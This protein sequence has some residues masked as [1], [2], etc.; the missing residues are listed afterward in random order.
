MRRSMMKPFGVERRSL[1]RAL[2]VGSFAASAWPRLAHAANDADVIVVGAGLS[3]L[4]A[5]LALEEAGK[6]VIVVEGRDRVGGRVLTL[7]VFGLPEVGGK[8]IGGTY[9]R[10]RALCERF[11][12]ELVERGERT[13]PAFA[14]QDM[15]WKGRHY[16]RE[17]WKA[18]A[19]NPFEGKFREALPWEVVNRFIA[20]KNPFT[21]VT[22]WV[23]PVKAAAH[24]VSVHQFLKAQNWSEAQIALAYSFSTGYGLSTHDVSM[25]MLFFIA[26]F[27]RAN[28]QADAVGSR[29][30]A[31]GNQRLP[32]AMAKGLRGDVVLNA[33]VA[34]LRTEK[35]YAEA[36]LEDGR[37]LR[38]KHLVC[39]L[40]LSAMRTL[41]I[42]PLLPPAHLEATKTVQYQKATQVFLKV[43]RP[44]WEEDGRRASMATD[45]LAGRLLGTR[46][47]ET[48]G[49]PAGFVSLHNGMRA[50][51]LDRYTDEDAAR[52]V[53][54]SLEE[55]RPS[56]KSAVEVTAVHSWQRDRFADGAWPVWAPGQALRLAKAS[57]VPHGRIHFC[58]E[59]TVY[60]T[61][62]MEAAVV[63][64]ERASAAIIAAG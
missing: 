27:S 1:L 20:E 58:G 29:E 25:L 39:S 16:T 3:G 48:P 62:G 56:L 44:F 2:V 7:P 19:E 9:L 23:D 24:D 53:V 33:P 18:A 54:K 64:G 11:K 4:A 47:P 28:F 37:T 5:A 13:L 17:S 8:G 43:N 26:A 12:L 46:V 35:N 36:V 52:A 63:S 59:H 34:A 15:V 6:R 30:V 45:A 57:A 40:P 32:E 31:G 21:E 22:D 42:D 38:A 60:H 61:R 50:D 49:G 10:L 55:I 51:T 41:P 14:G